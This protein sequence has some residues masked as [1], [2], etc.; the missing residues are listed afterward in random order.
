MKVPRQVSLKHL[1]IIVIS[2]ILL[3]SF[4]FYVFAATPSSTFWISSGVY[5]GAPSYTVWK[6]GSNYFAKDANGEIEFSGTNASEIVN[7]AIE[8]SGAYVYDAGV[9]SVVCTGT[10]TLDSPI[11]IT[12]NNW[13]HFDFTFDILDFTSNK[14]GICINS[15]DTMSVWDGKIE[16]NMLR[17]TYVNYNYSAL[18]ILNLEQATIEIGEIR[19]EGGA[20]SLGSAGIELVA[21]G[22]GADCSLNTIRV[23]R[24]SGYETGILLTTLDSGHIVENRFYD[25]QIIWVKNGVYSS[26][27]VISTNRFFSVA[28]DGTG[29]TLEY[30]F[31]FYSE[32]NVLFGCMVH[33]TPLGSIIYEYRATGSYEGN[34]RLRLYGCYATYGN[35]SSGIVHHG[36]HTAYSLNPAGYV[37]EYAGTAEAS[38]DDWVSF[39]LE[40]AGTPQTIILTVQESDARYIAQVKASNASHFQLYL[41]DETAGAAEA[42]NKTISWS[43]EYQP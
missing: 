4:A 35:F 31:Y 5:P 19:G 27:S 7:S 1:A 18:L 14:H 9:G 15:T 2:T 13:S 29:G 28:V 38:N 17:T 24:I 32:S 37:T 10:L 26:G 3:T 8:A 39:G 40:M 34:L 23:N 22:V 30:G 21:D 33:D 12:I 41:Y 20:S 42:V 43:A 25:S 16:G 36:T 6:E 11:N